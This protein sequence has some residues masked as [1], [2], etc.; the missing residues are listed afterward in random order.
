MKYLKLLLCLVMLS[1]GSISD[2]STETTN[3]SARPLSV[4][5][6]R[7]IVVLN[8]DK[9]SVPDVANDMA[10]EHSFG[11]RNVFQHAVRGFS[12]GMPESVVNKLRKDSRVKYIEEDGLASVLGK[13]EGAGK[14]PPKDGDSCADEPAQVTP[15]GITREGAPTPDLG[16][17]AWVIDTGIDL[18]NC[19]LNVDTFMA[20]NFVS[21][22]KNSADDKNG[23]G[24]HVA[25]TIAALDN[26]I[27]VVGV[28][29]C[30]YRLCCRKCTARRCS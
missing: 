28:V 9:Q 21:R 24:T 8:D 14:K 10:K 1:C 23:H 26:G 18:D 20:V 5:S 17:V 11:I 3:V 16:K 2:V 7:Y 13:P 27:D 22:G 12:A 29:R 6:K 15:Y 19:D 25:G 4:G 30:R